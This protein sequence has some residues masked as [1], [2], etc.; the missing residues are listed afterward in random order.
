MKKTQGL[1]P[2][3]SLRRE[4]PGRGAVVAARKLDLV[5][6]EP[7]LVAAEAEDRSA[8][9][10]K[11]VAR[12]ELV[13]SAIDIQIVVVLQTFRMSEE[14]DPHLEC[15]ENEVLAT[16]DDT[17][18]AD[19]T[20]A[21][22]DAELPRDDQEVV[23]LLRLRDLLHHFGFPGR[24]AQ[25]V[26]THLV[27][28][29]VVELALAGFVQLREHD[30]DGFG[31]SRDA[32]KLRE[33]LPRR[34]DEQSF[35]AFRHGH[36]C[37]LFVVETHARKE[38]TKLVRLPDDILRLRIPRE[39]LVARGGFFVGIQLRRTRISDELVDERGETG[40]IVDVLGLVVGKTGL[41]VGGIDDGDELLPFRAAGFDGC[42]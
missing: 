11:P 40:G 38:D 28:A 5:R 6:V 41:V 14:H 12:L 22:H 8:R 23:A 29:V 27:L 30:L 42:N 13:A 15:A 37:G 36:L 7:Q 4:E 17:R 32:M 24:F 3:E 18:A 39:V 9:E 2:Q 16:D 21:M 10:V 31:V 34:D 25:V 33:G 1:K 35:G 26:R 19:R 20:A